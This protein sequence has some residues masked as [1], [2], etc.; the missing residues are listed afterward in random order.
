M[1]RLLL[2]PLAL[3]AALLV[4]TAA[5]ADTKTVQIT[6]AGFSPK[7]TTI[8]V[9]DTVTWHNADT[10]THQVV[11]NNGSFASPVLKAD[12][13]WSH[14]FAAA[15]NLN[16][17]D[18]QNTKNTGTVRVTGAAAA[19]SL[20]ADRTKITYGTGQSATLSGTVN[21]GAANE[22]V[23]LSSLA[24]GQTA[25]QAGSTTKTTGAN[26]AFDFSVSP[27]IQTVY[28]V[29]WKNATSSPVTV[30]VAPRVGF[31]RTG[32]LYLTRVSSELSYRGHFVWVQRHTAFGWR[33][34]KQVVLKSGSRAIFGLRL[35]HGRTVLR[36]FLP[37]AQAGAGYVASTSR[38]LAIRR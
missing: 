14:T 26:G 20:T 35:P 29:H 6:A 19:V 28:T 18:S 8:N 10:S 9:G 27:S 25:A 4:A 36:V 23:T 24:Y 5:G 32:R 38:L 15:A 21:S 31:G 22:Q 37:S 33:N 30:N 16:Y 34:M 1:K 17:H 2:L 7:A 13:T 12:E 11:A 3:V